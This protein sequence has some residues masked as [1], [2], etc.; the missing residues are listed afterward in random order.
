MAIYIVVVLI[1][2]LLYYASLIQKET[3]II[4]SEIDNN[5]YIIRSGKK[6]KK[7]LID[8]ANTLGIINKRVEKLITHLKEKYNTNDNNNLFIEKLIDN[9]NPSIL[10]EAA[11]DNRFTTFTVDKRDMHICLRT[12][13]KK[14]E[15]YNIDILMYVVLHELAHLCNYDN[16][17][18]PIIGHG[19]EFKKI[20]R[21]L[22]I[23]SM[24]I[25][26]YKYTNYITSP[27]EYCGIIINSSII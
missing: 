3:V 16:D 14:E 19:A 5:S 23:E 27:V 1:I 15:L 20:F 4:K 13:D 22:V 11:I 7:Y 24:N 12:R 17:G 25:G 8:S 2:I 10:S 21:L 9:Y 6:S 26:I 18:N